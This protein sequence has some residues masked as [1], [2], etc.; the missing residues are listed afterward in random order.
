MKNISLIRCSLF[1]ATFGILATASFSAHSSVG[2]AEHDSKKG[3]AHEDGEEHEEEG[4]E[5]EETGGRFGVGKAI[6]AASRKTGIQLSEK[7]VKSL[8]LSYTK[9]EGGSPFKVPL[10]C[11]VFFQKEVGIYRFKNG[12]YKLVE[13]ELLSK[14]STEATVKAS[15]LT[16]GDQIVKDGV[17][18]LRAAELEAWGGSGD[19]H[20]H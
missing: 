1:V 14:T 9:L 7:A 17:P 20:G 18:L 12:R 13:V 3:H 8:G 15:E 19:G 10:K 4:E 11:V 2:E 6:V 16:S 5:E